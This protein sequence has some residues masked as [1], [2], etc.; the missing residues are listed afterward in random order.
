MKIS[1]CVPTY[2]RYEMLLRCIAYPLVDDRVDE[3]IIVDDHSTDDS[4][5]K[6]TIMLDR[7]RKVK[8]FRNS[9]NMDCY[10]NKREALRNATNDWCILFDSDN[11][12]GKDYIDKLYEQAVWDDNMAYLPS[13]AKPH[14]DYRAH[15]GLVYT[16]EN[17]HRYMQHDKFRC[18]LNTANYFV[19]RN[20]Y[21]EL[22]NEDVNPHTADSMYMNFRYLVAGK[23]LAIVP[24]LQ[25]E[26]LVHEGSHYKNNC[27]KTGN[28]ATDIENRL[29]NLR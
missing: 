25:Y 23:T 14:F 11:V 15:E 20:T 24:G 21:L 6:L 1:F 4:F 3:I 22:W 16:K 12:L 28:I 5:K 29:R 17:V 9:Y 8:L 13:F 19:N 18:A 27:H 26:H 2:Q 7:V 10:A